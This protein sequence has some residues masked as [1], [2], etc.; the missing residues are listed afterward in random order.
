MLHDL[1]DNRAEEAYPHIKGKW[2][3]QH[4]ITPLVR[5]IK[6]GINS[7]LVCCLVVR[8]MV[9][10]VTGI[11]YLT[12]TCSS[13]H[14]MVQAGI[15]WRNIWVSNSGRDFSDGGVQDICRTRQQAKY[16]GHRAPSSHGQ[17][18]VSLMVYRWKGVHIGVA[19]TRHLSIY[20]LSARS[21]RSLWLH[22]PLTV[23]DAVGDNFF[24]I[25]GDFWVELRF[26]F[27][28]FSHAP[29]SMH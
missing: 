25:L 16:Q 18:L 10:W 12:C 8:C 22:R 14:S 17:W 5:P 23:F 29:P 20:F 9:V 21:K 26:F 6:P 24:E 3:T 4:H 1:C 19:D 13:T 27:F 28:F 11:Q 2:I 15:P 7:V